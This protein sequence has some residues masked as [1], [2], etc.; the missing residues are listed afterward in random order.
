MLSFLGVRRL[1]II[2]AKAPSIYGTTRPEA[3]RAASTN[4]E[5]QMLRTEGG[6]KISRVKGFPGREHAGPLGPAVHQAFRRFHDNRR[7]HRIDVSPARR[8]SPLRTS[9]SH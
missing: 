7:S 2:C 5:A 6:Q 9:P 3:M 8:G 4:L 1:S